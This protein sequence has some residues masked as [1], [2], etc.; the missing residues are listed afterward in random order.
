MALFNGNPSNNSLLGSNNADIINGLGGNDTLSGL[1]GKDSIS[2]GADNDHLFGGN[3]KDYL[4]GDAG[5]DSLD[6]GKGIDTAAIHAAG[7]VLVTKT[8][9]I[10]QGLDSINSIERVV[11]FG[12][13]ANQ[14]MVAR[15]YSGRVKF[16]GYGG[17][18]TFLGTSQNGRGRDRHIRR[19]RRE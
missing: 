17:N 4:S 16:Y 11:A 15:N 7:S 13:N 6:G 14:L 9:I 3:G 19:G 10:G 1:N 2:G 18:D 12:G 8:E 5:D